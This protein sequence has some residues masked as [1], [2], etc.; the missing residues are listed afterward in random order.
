MAANV[1]LPR[2]HFIV[3]E[4]NQTDIEASMKQFT[5]LGMLVQITELDIRGVATENG[6][7]VLNYTDTYQQARDFAA[8]VDA[9]ENNANCPGVTVWNFDDNSSWVPGVFAPYGDATLYYQN[10]A[11]KPAY[12]AMLE[13]FQQRQY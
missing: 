8:V 3:G 10:L 9:C 6:V 4:V 1:A 5:D 2:S 12:Y 13:A 11:P 7:G